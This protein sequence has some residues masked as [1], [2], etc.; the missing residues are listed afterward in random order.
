MR[1]GYEVFHVLKSWNT[2]FQ[3]RFIT[4]SGG[5][6]VKD[7][8]KEKRVLEVL[9]SR[10]GKYSIRARKIKNYEYQMMELAPSLRYRC[11]NRDKKRFIWM[12]KRNTLT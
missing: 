3:R 8:I 12:R 6:R 10:I 1:R 11:K 2:P 9:Q 7:H 5:K 4:E